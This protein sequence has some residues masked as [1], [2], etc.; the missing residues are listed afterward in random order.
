[1]EIHP[2]P[3]MKPCDFSGLN[4]GC[5]LS[6]KMT[7]TGWFGFDLAGCVLPAAVATVVKGGLLPS[8]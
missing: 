7:P 5:P 4:R 6:V 8:C 3:S 1:M 2:I